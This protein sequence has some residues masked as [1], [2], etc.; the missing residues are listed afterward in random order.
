MPALPETPLTANQMQ[1]LR[2][3]L[4]THLGGAVSIEVWSREDGELFTGERDVNPQGW[5]ALSLMRQIK[6]SHAAI[7]VTP[8]DIDRNAAGATERGI[9]ESPVVIMRARGHSIRLVGVFFGAV[10]Q[11]FLDQLGYLSTGRTPLAPRNLDRLQAIEDEVTIEAYLSAFDPIS[12]QM[13]PLLGA[14]AVAGKR[15]R[16]TEIESSQFPIHAGKRLISQVPTLFIN[17]KRFVGH[18][19]EAQLVEQIEQVL[20]GSDEPVERE[21]VLA[22][23]YMSDEE[24]RRQ[25]AAR[26]QAAETS[27]TLS[28]APGGGTSQPGS[29]LYVPGQR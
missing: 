14:F 3:W 22:N 12:L 20:T 15:I 19:N 23:P 29:G 21:R 25:M 18:Y 6:A 4:K 11:P 28:A 27:G 24:V 5:M 1:V 2:N 8:Y 17:G 10:F 9:T 7:S 13:I 16:V 26:Q